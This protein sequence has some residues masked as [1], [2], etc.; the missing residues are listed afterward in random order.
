MEAITAE[1]LAA[2]AAELADLSDDIEYG[3]LAKKLDNNDKDDGKYDDDD[4]R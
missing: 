2:I 4:E 1:N 3:E